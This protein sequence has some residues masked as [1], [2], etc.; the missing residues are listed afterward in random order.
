M[1]RPLSIF[2][3]LVAACA[4]VACQSV[5]YSSA[6]EREARGNYFEAA[7]MYKKVL[8]KVPAKNTA[9]RGEVAFRQGEML[10]KINSSRASNA[11]NSA[12]RFK[13]ADNM[14]MFRQAQVLQKQGKYAEAIK[15]YNSFLA[16]APAPNLAAWARNGIEGCELAPEWKQKPTSYEVRK[17]DKIVAREGEFAPMLLGADQLY[18]SSPRKEAKGDKSPITGTKNNDFF[19]VKQDDKGVWSKP[20]AVAGLNT[21]SDEG[22]AAFT[23]DGSKMYYTFCSAGNA[24]DSQTADI[25]V[26]NR[27]GG[28]WNAG[29]KVELFSEPDIM[30]AHPAVGGDGYLY[31]VSDAPWGQGGKDLWRVRIADIGEAKPENLG[32]EINTPGDEVFPY[33]RDDATLYFSSDGHPGM[34]GLDIFK[35]NLV[36]G[37]WRVENMKSPVNSMS[38][39]FGITYYPQKETGFFSSNR[40]DGR[41]ADHI[42]SFHQPGIFAYIEGLITD[43][44]DV[45]IPGAGVRLVGT[46]G[47]NQ[48]LFARAD[49][50]YQVEVKPGV[51]YV[52]MASAP[53]FLNQ[54]QTVKVPQISKSR[55]FYADFKLR[56]WLRPE[57]VE[58]IYFDFN[59]ATLRANSKPALDDIIVTLNANSSI[60]IEVSAHTDRIG[61]DAS[62]KE[63]S[64]RRAQAVVNFL[65]QGGIDKERLKAKGY[66]K[67][68]PLVVTKKIAEAY[69]FLPEGQV[70]DEKFI[71]TLDPVQQAQTDQINRRTAFKVLSSNY[72]KT[73]L[74]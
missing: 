61:S 41:G 32:P 24:G 13:Y 3:A 26:S 44:E 16:T 31:F 20:E 19:F 67:S 8:A 34:G 35:A 38:D 25:Y 53:N 47:S 15:L 28:Q 45:K 56:S 36:S 72:Q 60:T 62:N 12:I 11:Y 43:W 64:Q 70:L 21:E 52:M 18:F 74:R 66:G 7:D 63:M 1:H 30:A 39:D 68:E 22:T 42:Y 51:E 29:E 4:L 27:S 48:R 69:D 50:T 71:R 10:R 54:P 49:G 65:I 46:D 14:V 58:N 9:L 33:I 40:D 37:Y 23:A 2:I 55:T 57:V 5:S 6:K 73:K 17:M 59:R